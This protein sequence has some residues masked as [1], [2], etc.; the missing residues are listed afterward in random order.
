MGSAR[1]FRC[2]A[3]VIACATFAFGVVACGDEGQSETVPP[4]PTADLYVSSTG[5]DDGAGT[6]AAP[7]AS[8]TRA[9]AAARSGE[10]VEVAGGEYPL[11]SLWRPAESE[12][13]AVVIRPAQG[14][15]VVLAGLQLD[16]VDDVEIHDM[17]TTGW[18]IGESSE[19]VTFKGVHSRGSG[20]FITSADDIRIIGGSIGP[21][22]SSDGLQI[23]SS[24]D[25]PNPT[26]ILI[27]GL[28]M[29]DITR[30]RE[31]TNHVDC[32]QVGGAVDL[33][34]RNSRFQNCATQGIFLRPFGGGTIRD[35]LIENNWVGEILE[36]TSGLIVDEDVGPGANVRVRN[37][38]VVQGLRVEP[39]GVRVIANIAPMQSYGCVAGVIYRYNIWSDATCG[40]TDRSGPPGYVDVAAFDLNLRAGAAAID[41]GDPEDA[42]D[43]D[44]DGVARPQGAKPD[45]GA[46]E[47]I[48]G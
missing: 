13:P 42:P 4:E 7:F 25:G 32:V 46:S 37:N 18:Y 21:V 28:D 40:S 41:A 6:A 48:P 47:Y 34:I 2:G 27:D 39:A 5:S 45:A 26:G 16:D 36:G 8:F 30:R 38:S 15:R 19:R 9:L 29:H 23:K 35:V 12:L 1:G 44:I 43:T 14:E 24:T 20:S 22:D 17:T 11:Q 33:V 3:V 31:P 10:V